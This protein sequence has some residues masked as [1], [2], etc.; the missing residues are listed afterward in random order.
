MDYFS[1]IKRNE[2]HTAWMSLEN[3]LSKRS[4]L[5]NTIYCMISFIYDQKMQICS[6]KNQISSCLKLEIK[7][8]ANTH[9]GTLWG[10][11]NVLNLGCNS[12]CTAL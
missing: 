9:E 6:D 5:Q 11:G 2:A 4:Q 12:G 10:F 8:T 3:M 7:L 1:Y